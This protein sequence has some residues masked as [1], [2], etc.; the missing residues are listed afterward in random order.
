MES[1]AVTGKDILEWTDEK[2][3][4]RVPQVKEG[5][6]KVQVENQNGVS[7][8][9]EAQILLGDQ[10][11]SLVKSVTDSKFARILLDNRSMPHVI[12]FEQTMQSPVYWYWIGSK[13]GWNRRHVRIPRDPGQKLIPAVG[14]FPSIAWDAAGNLHIT[15][16]DLF[17]ENFLYGQHDRAKD[18]WTFHRP[19]PGTKAVGMFTSLAVRPDGE[20]LI[21][22]MSW[23]DGMLKLARGKEGKFTITPID[24]KPNHKVGMT[25]SL[26]LDKN[27]DP[28]IA[29]LDF[30]AKDLKYAWWDPAKKSF[31]LE[32]VDSTGHVGEFAM[33][34][35]GKEDSPHVVYFQRSTQASEK[36]GLKL[37]YR[38]KD[39]WKSQ[40]IEEGVGV[41]YSP[42]MELDADG[43]VHA[44]YLSRNDSAVHYAVGTP[45]KDFKIGVH[46]VEKLWVPEEPVN[47]DMALG[48]DGMARVVFWTD[49]PKT[50]EIKKL[51]PPK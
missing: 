8:P 13:P 16:Y 27:G 30:E 32:T 17:K 3:R 20:A 4:I 21:A 18:S 2:I 14:W 10:S 41:G 37:A 44:V 22:Y 51:E 11:G 48:L 7:L 45:G 29:Y 1:E 49:P 25:P 50:L 42:A 34:R 9:T 43:R 6:T 12:F 38:G 36:D 40:V 19:D 23:N 47:L 46:K 39:G 33:L 24:G 5:V 26:R 28:N 15:C 31:S 35:L